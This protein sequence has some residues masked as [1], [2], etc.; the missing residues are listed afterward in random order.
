MT[1]EEPPT[2]PAFIR[3]RAARDGNHLTQAPGIVA[4]RFRYDSQECAAARTA[5][6]QALQTAA[7]MLV[8]VE[9]A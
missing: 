7:P 3:L 2:A 8:E 6:T 1:T 5:L 4:L 9:V